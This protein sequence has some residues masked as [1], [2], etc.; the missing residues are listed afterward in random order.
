MQPQQQAASRRRT[1]SQESTNVIAV[2]VLVTNGR[3][4]RPCPSMR[5]PLHSCMSCAA[6]RASCSAEAACNTANAQGWH[7]E[8]CRTPRVRERTCV[9]QVAF[10]TAVAAVPRSAANPL[11]STLN[12]AGR[13]VVVV[14][15]T[16]A[17]SLGRIRLQS[18]ASHDDIKIGKAKEL[19]L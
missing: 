15:V 16:V 11:G 10:V 7:A 9:T 14:A 5:G 8:G 19:F 4:G 13:V 3:N 6:V 1:A 12:Q 18:T 17:I 2:F